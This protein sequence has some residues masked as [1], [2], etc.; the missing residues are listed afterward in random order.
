MLRRRFIFA[1]AAATALR[2]RRALAGAA[3]GHK[4]RV[5]RALAARDVDRPPF[6]FWH[7]FNLPTPEAHA[8][9]TLRFHRDYRTDI[10]KVMSDFPYPKP[11]GKW[12]E[13]MPEANPFAPQVKALNLIRNGLNGRAPFVETIFN[14]WNV[15]EKLSSTQEV[16][17][18]KKDN[19]QALLNALDVIA[20]SEANH[21]KRAIDAGA[22]GVFLSVANA[23]SAT[24]TPEEYERFSLPFDRRILEAVSGAKLNILHVHVERDYLRFFPNFPAQVF[25]YSLHVSHI[26]IADVRREFGGVI[27]GGVDEVNY[28]TLSESELASQWHAARAAAGPKYI[29]TPGCSVPN[30][31]TRTELLRLPKVLGA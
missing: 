31:S 17:R 10:V 4:E 8:D 19:P 15:A 6:S 23:N 11:A 24:L 20:R 2:S 5:D 13:L 12:Y 21:A 16:Q 26:P 18:M 7:H 27:A 22:A 1:T 14:P 25:N 3:L 9:A 29:L 28:R 30:E